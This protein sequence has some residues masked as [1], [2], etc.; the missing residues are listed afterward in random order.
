[1]YSISVPQRIPPLFS[2]FSHYL[3]KVRSVPTVNCA[4]KF[5]AAFLGNRLWSVRL[6]M[7]GSL[8]TVLCPLVFFPCIYGVLMVSG[9][10]PLNICFGFLEGKL[11]T[12]LLI[13]LVYPFH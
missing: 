10:K 12:G 1:M 7:Y 3:S 11:H 6:L 4:L 9:T 2:F 8:L 13:H 5:K